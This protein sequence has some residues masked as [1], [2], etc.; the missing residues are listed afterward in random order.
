MTPM[1]PSPSHVTRVEIIDLVTPQP[2]TRLPRFRDVNLPPLSAVRVFPDPVYI[3]STPK[4][5]P[6]PEL[7]AGAAAAAVAAAGEAAYGA[8]FAVVDT[9]WALGSLYTPKKKP[10]KQ[11]QQFQQFQQVMGDI[12]AD[13]NAELAGYFWMGS[14]GQCLAWAN[15]ND[16][17]GKLCK[18]VP[19]CVCKKISVR[20]VIAIN[21]GF[22]KLRHKSKLKAGTIIALNDG[23][24][25]QILGEELGEEPTWFTRVTRKRK[26]KHSW[27]G[28]GNR[29]GDM[30]ENPVA[31]AFLNAKKRRKDLNET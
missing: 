8:L 18:S 9:L 31:V 19:Y 17:L 4:Y 28:K 2:Q 13:F 1:S 10:A 25:A 29:V 14:R 12:E 30:V 22:Y 15:E 21:A 27:N 11:F 26:R 20:K 3:P 24:R 5:A 16:T 23:G 6:E 7:A